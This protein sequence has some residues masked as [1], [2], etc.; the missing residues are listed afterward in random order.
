MAQIRIDL[1]ETL[2][3]GMDIKFKAPCACNE[4]TGLIV[5]YP[6]EDETIKSKELTFRDAHGNDLTGIGNLF[7][8][9]A[10]VKVI[11][12]IE[13]G[14]AYLQNAD[15]NGYLNSAIF[16]TYTHDA[17]NLIGGGE[18]GKFKATV[19][20]TISSINVNGVSC[21]VRCGED[22][23]MDLVAGCWYTFIL[24][25]NT[26][27]FN[28]GGAGGG[29]NFKV[30]G[31]T[32]A[33]VSPSEN[34]I[35]INTDVP[36]TSYIFS[37]KEPVKKVNNLIPFPNEAVSKTLNGVTYTVNPDGTVTLNGTV[38]SS[39]D[40][41]IIDPLNLNWVADEKYTFSARQISGTASLA[42]G[43]S[44]TTF[45]W[46]IFQNNT[47]KCIRGS[48]S[49]PAFPEL[50]TFTG[51]AFDLTEA[52]GYYILYFQCWRP[53]TVFDNYTVRIQLETGETATEPNGIADEGM[54]W[55]KIGTESSVEFNA[56]KK[57]GLQ[58]YPISAKQYIDG[59]WVDK[60]AKS[61]QNGEW[62]E[63]IFYAFKDGEIRLGEMYTST[64]ERLY[65]S[66]GELIFKN[67]S[68]NGSWG[69]FTETIDLT[70]YRKMKAKMK[71]SSVHNS[72]YGLVSVTTETPTAETIPNIKAR[73]GA[74]FELT[75][76]DGA[77]HELETSVEGFSGAYYVE[78]AAIAVGAIS[79]IWFE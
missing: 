49:L 74:Y 65:I 31:D 12:D 10:Y 44:T 1:A 64:P 42:D 33:P 16:G 68:G 66:N 43:T 54:V 47:A 15:N 19:S 21:S 40:L 57:N 3:D 58:V 24:D 69:Y 14:Y 62:V 2:L 34:M 5:F 27:N 26:V 23:T 7:S 61:Y 53:G 22:T 75:V 37:A 18:N 28:A 56:L 13:N 51:T 60:A 67:S 30:V 9:D 32:T 38:T 39:G 71:Q 8:K 4:I 72:Y 59:A 46:G 78:V 11:A 45:S 6:G 48:V 63:W 41:K 25:G 76:K 73:S 17:E 50:Y 29:L 35:W 20:G 70:S 77:Y 79:E 52:N 55:I 36:I